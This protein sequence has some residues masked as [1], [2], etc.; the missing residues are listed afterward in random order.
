MKSSRKTAFT[1]VEL[2]VVIGI[3]AVLI[4]ILLPALSKAREQANMVKCSSNLRSIG[5]AIAIYEAN[6]GGSLPPSNFYVGLTINGNTQLPASP[7]SGYVHW[8][9]LLFASYLGPQDSRFFSTSGWEMFQCPSLI[10]GGVP[11]ANTYAGN[12]DAGLQNETYPATI[13]GQPVVDMQAPRMSYMLN[14][15]LTPRSIFTLN[16]RTTSGKQNTRYYYF[17]RA[18]SVSNSASTILATEMWGIQT[19]MEASSNISG[20]GNVSNSR[21]PV[22]GISL[23]ETNTLPANSA[24]SYTIPKSDAPYNLPVGGEFGWAKVDD[25]H[26]DP[27]SFYSSNNPVTTPP[28]TTLD[29]I[30]RNHGVGKPIGNVAGSSQGGWDLRKSNFLYLDGHV[31][32]KHVSETVYPNSQW[33]AKFYSL[34]PY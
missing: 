9:A 21:R 27:S 8:S 30:G 11:P 24:G 4:G 14:E 17:V 3:I 20:G 12:N 23:K 15:A 25:M 5:Q 19:I 10:N 34:P 6:Y 26:P 22:S 18:G 28:D 13:N 16:F 32:T 33:G 7:T 29:F 1:L 31:E 2:L